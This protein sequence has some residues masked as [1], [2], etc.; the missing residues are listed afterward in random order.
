MWMLLF[1]ACPPP[2]ESKESTP[3]VQDDSCTHPVWSGILP[4]PSNALATRDAATV[5]GLELNI[6]Q[7]IM[8]LTK[9]GEPAIDAAQLA[10]LDGFSRLAPVV[11]A[12]DG[13]SDG[14]AYSTVS[15]DSNAQIFL[16]DLTDNHIV[17]SRLAVTNGGKTLVLWPDRA[18]EPNHL[19][20]TVLRKDLPTTG[21]FSAGPDYEAS[22][23]AGD[24]FAAEIAQAEAAA[25]SLGVEPAVVIPFTT[26]SLEQEEQ[27][28]DALAAA[29]PGLIDGDSMVVEEVVDCA[30]GEKSGYCGDGVGFVLTGHVVMPK[31]QTSDGPFELDVSRAAIQ[32]GTEDLEFWLLVPETAR[33]TAAPVMVVQHG[34]GGDKE[35]M[36]G[37]GREFV[38]AGYAAIA[39]DAVVHGSRPHTG[40]TTSAFFGIDFDR[41]HVE[42]ARDN[43]R[44]TSSDHLGLLEA[45]V[46]HA[47]DGVWSEGFRLNTEDRSYFGISLGGI[48]GAS[49][50]P[51]NPTLD[52]CVLNVPGGRLVEIVRANGAYSAL[53]NIFFDPNE[54]QQEIELFSALAQ[55]VVDEGDPAIA[56]AR[57]VQR[58]PVRPLLVQEAIH[59]TT[60][61]NQT[62]E[63]MV[64]S[65]GLPLLEPEL[66]AIDGL[67]LE[68]APAAENLATPDGMFTASLTQFDEEHSFFGG[69]SAEGQRALHQ[70]ITFLQTERIETSE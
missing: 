27:T 42:T 47:P 1:L 56:A 10:G 48:I 44:Q 26:R 60:V 63:V 9:G 36:L 11:V 20:A 52:R 13:G 14:A 57:V 46:D 58:S 68:P 22:K 34:L 17:R 30:V 35:S 51:L 21:C 53:M 40:N 19:H 32:Q 4:F 12:L 41:W 29:M 6:P 50:C 61:Y 16:M 67:E 5:T 31:W 70:A 43:L 65:I 64:R 49:S 45:L 69:G 2:D 33:E 37:I 38:R 54:G 55:S 15:E 18:L 24:A 66:E 39:I 28:V 23:A 7:E 3:V 25:Q 59:D 8:P 62:T